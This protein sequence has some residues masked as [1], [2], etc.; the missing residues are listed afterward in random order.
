MGVVGN[1][2]DAL[3]DKQRDRVIEAKDW[4]WA[5]LDSDDPSCRCLVGHAEDY[6]ENAGTPVARDRALLPD[7]EW[8]CLEKS[9]YG[10]NLP[11]YN[12]VP[13]L[14][15]RFGKDRI[16]ALCKARAAKGNRLHDIRS[17]VYKALVPG[18]GMNGRIEDLR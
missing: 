7:G 13:L 18:G 2:L 12:Q 14:F 3:S 4:T 10:R 8:A 17:Q 11:V 6:A 1:Y 5:F 16:V 9:K 15:E